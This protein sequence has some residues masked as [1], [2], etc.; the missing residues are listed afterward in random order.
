VLSEVE[1]PFCFIIE[2]K[3]GPRQAQ[4]ETVSI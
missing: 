4:G 1:A 2:E 3:N